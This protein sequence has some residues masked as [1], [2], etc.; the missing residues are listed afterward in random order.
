MLL[1]T[2]AA[3]NALSTDPGWAT[4]QRPT[5]LLLLLHLVHHLLLLQLLR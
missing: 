2:G 1:H 3:Y 5:A 4:G